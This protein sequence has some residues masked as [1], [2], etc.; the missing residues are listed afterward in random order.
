MVNGALSKFRILDLSDYIGGPF[1]AK[2]FGDY[3]A[4]VIKV[5]PPG[6]GDVARTVGP[7]FKDDPHPEKSLL[8][9]YL[10]CNKRGVTLNIEA[11][12]GRKL[13]LKLVKGAD[14]LI[15]A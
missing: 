14:A 10:N 8:F 13:L 4:D 15:E 11:S 1:C 9:F 2:L 3:G 5:E 7:F 12:A 6:V